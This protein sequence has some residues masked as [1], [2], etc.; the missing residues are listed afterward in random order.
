M[1]RDKMETQTTIATKSQL[2]ASAF[3]PA[4]L[5]IDVCSRASQF[6]Y[7][8]FRTDLPGMPLIPAR[9]GFVVTTVRGTTS[10]FMKRASHG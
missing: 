6:R 2:K 5:E 10:D 3:I 8:V 1:L 7:P 4:I 9:L